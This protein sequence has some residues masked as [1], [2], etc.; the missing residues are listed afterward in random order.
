MVKISILAETYEALVSNGGLF[1][2]LLAIAMGFLTLGLLSQVSFP[3]PWDSDQGGGE[4]WGYGDDL[5]S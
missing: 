3:L 2:V 5:V 1:S 4:R